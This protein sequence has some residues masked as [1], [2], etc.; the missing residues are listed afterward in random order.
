MA[1]KVS[2]KRPVLVLVLAAALAGGVW[3]QDNAAAA[4][5]GQPA[6]KFTLTIDAA[7][8][9]KGLIASDSDD[10][11]THFGLGAV[12]EFDFNGLN[13]GIRADLG[14]TNFDGTSLTYFG[15]AAIWRYYPIAVL[16]KLYLSTE[17]GFS[18]EKLD[19]SG[20]DPVVGLTFGLRAGW[21]QQFKHV[22]IEP[23]MGY[24]YSKDSMGP[25]GLHGWQAGL[26]IGFAL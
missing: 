11:T 12:L 20:T 24:G 5:S 8:T 9:L 16:T 1:I 10:N 7:P 21:R 17:V 2:F 25:Y 15:A 13:A 18:Y 22:F 4:P 26:G 14:L 23:S 19:V 6:N 3:A